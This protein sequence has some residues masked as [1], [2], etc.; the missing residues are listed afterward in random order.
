MGKSVNSAALNFGDG[1]AY[2]LT[3]ERACRLLFVGDDFS[4][5]AIES[6]L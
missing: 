2:L 3:R 5:A 4:E 1:F 6:V